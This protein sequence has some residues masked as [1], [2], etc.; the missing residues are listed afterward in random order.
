MEFFWINNCFHNGPKHVLTP[1]KVYIQRNYS[2][3]VHQINKRQIMHPVFEKCT[4]KRWACC[5]FFILQNVKVW[6]MQEIQHTKHKAT[7]TASWQKHS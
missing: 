1:L 7:Q 3:L 2:V 6:I 5:N 4:A